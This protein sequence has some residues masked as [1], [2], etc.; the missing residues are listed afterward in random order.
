M[1][2]KMLRSR[3]VKK[4]QV[5]VPGGRTKTHYKKEKPKKA[6][7]GIC[8][9]ELKGVPKVRPSDLK[10]LSKTEKRPERPYG[11]VLCSKCMREIYRKKAREV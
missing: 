5:K 6:R 10:K 2:R 8:G 3:S 9:S 11:G 7:C 1:V 4:T